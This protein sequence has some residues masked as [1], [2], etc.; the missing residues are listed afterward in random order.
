MKHLRSINKRQTGT[1]WMAILQKQIWE[2]SRALWDHRNK[3]R[4]PNDKDNIHSF[5][6]NAID[7]EIRQEYRTGL[8]YLPPSYNYLFSESL[9]SLLK[10]KYSDKHNWLASVWNGRDL[11]AKLPCDV[12]KRNIQVTGFYDQWKRRRKRRRLAM[13]Q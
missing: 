3:I 6:K 1:H 5:E 7:F 10:R 2:L 11:F 9:G 12:R 13:Q 4:H 8:Q